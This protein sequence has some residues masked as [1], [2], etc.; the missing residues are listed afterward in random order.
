MYMGVSV[1]ED[2]KLCV[3]FYMY[4]YFY[5]NKIIAPNPLQL[6]LIYGLWMFPGEVF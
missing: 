3:L 4:I 2:C 1:Y 6:H 5:L